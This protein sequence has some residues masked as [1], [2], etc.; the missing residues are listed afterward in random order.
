MHF[1]GCKLVQFLDSFLIDIFSQ[2]QCFS[3]TLE[4]SK[5]FVSRLRLKHTRRVLALT[6]HIDMSKH[7][8]KLPCSWISPNNQKLKMNKIKPVVYMV[9]FYTIFSPKGGDS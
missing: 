9:C 7:V 3:K 8:D 2:L 1:D 5:I 4:D 6:I